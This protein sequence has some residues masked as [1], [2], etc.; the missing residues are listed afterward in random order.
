MMARR[1]RQLHR[2]P[3]PARPSPPLASAPLPRLQVLETIKE[4][5]SLYRAPAGAQPAAADEGEA[6][7]GL[8]TPRLD[9]DDLHKDNKNVPP[10]LT[11]AQAQTLDALL[12]ARGRAR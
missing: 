12:G 2:T 3:R 5:K 11:P 6:W 8:D 1:W 4:G 10:R 9:P 7:L